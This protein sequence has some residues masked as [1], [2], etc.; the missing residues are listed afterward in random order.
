MSSNTDRPKTMWHSVRWFIALYL[1][2]LVGYGV[3]ELCLH[4]VN[5]LLLRLS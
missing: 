4:Y 1:I 2:G 3:I 5:V